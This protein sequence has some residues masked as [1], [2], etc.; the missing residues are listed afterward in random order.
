MS[1]NF[2]NTNAYMIGIDAHTFCPAVPPGAQIPAWPHIV[3][4]KFSG[5]SIYTSLT[6]KTKSETH[7]MVKEGWSLV[8]VPH[9]PLPAPPGPKELQEYLIL[10]VTSGS[11]PVLAI[12]S[13]TGE[14]VSLTVCVSGCVG[15]N[16]N[17]G[18]F[19][20]DMITGAVLCFSTVQTT[21]TLSDFVGAAIKTVATSIV[22]PIVGFFVGKSFDGLGLDKRLTKPI[23]KK[24][25][26]LAKPL[27][28]FLARRVTKQLAEKSTPPVKAKVADKTNPI[29]QGI[30]NAMGI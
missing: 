1:V 30:V 3:G 26:E 9:I 21:P 11:E 8:A 7:A 25:V 2:L 24:A 15:W 22:A 16:L 18:P 19:E 17:C 29:A 14:G 27:V 12:G 13:V 10:V 6:T 5:P 4:M 23:L 28:E 20:S